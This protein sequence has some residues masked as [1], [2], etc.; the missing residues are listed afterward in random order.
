MKRVPL[1][2]QFIENVGPNSVLSNLRRMTKGAV[3]VDIAVAFISSSGLSH[4]LPAL[5]RVASRGEVRILTGLYQGITDPRAL[6]TLL[7]IQEQT[8][9]CL[10]VRISRESK[11]HRKLYL[12][13]AGGNVKA[14]VGSSN[15]TSDGLS[16]GGE[17]NVYLSSAARSAPMRRLLRAF[18][19]DW[20]NRAVPLDEE[21]I[22]RYAQSQSVK[23][24]KAR[25]KSLPLRSILGTRTTSR[26]AKDERPES[27]IS[28]WRD[29]VDGFVSKQTVA[30]IAST[31]DWDERGYSW[32]S[33]GSHRFKLKDRILMFDF[34]KD[35]VQMV[36]VVGITRTAVR[37]PDGVHFVAY[38]PGRGQK[39]RRLTPWRWKGLKAALGLTR[40]SEFLTRHRLSPERWSLAHEALRAAR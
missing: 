29:S 5:Q 4:L 27:P 30:I 17:L 38:K 10:S 6:S 40:R 13:R 16:S 11:F 3:D 23:Q 9:G 15:L 33:A 24:Q 34:T 1:S 12:V 36:Q 21:I 37:T 35:S 19:D 32:Y 2:F 39:A 25:T 22:G 28:F 8:R 20:E 7:D 18:D 31:T 14:V 26:R